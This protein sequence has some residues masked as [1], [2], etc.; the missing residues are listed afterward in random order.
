MH[1]PLETTVTL[2][3][4]RLALLTLVRKS[5]LIEATWSEI[6]FANAVWSIP[7]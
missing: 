7:K 6:D 1:R 2:P 4:V 5:E 3:T